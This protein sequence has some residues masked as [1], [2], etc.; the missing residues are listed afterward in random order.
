MPKSMNG[1][2]YVSLGFPVNV[3]VVMQGAVQPL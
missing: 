2:E 1:E 3:K